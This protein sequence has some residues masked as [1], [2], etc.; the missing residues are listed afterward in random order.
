MGAEVVVGE[1][2]G[3]GQ[4]YF[5]PYWYHGVGVT[6]QRAHC[7][8]LSARL[9]AG[10]WSWKAGL[11]GSLGKVVAVQDWLGHGSWEQLNQAPFGLT[12][13]GSGK[14]TQRP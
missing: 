6:V 12:E 5:L 4:F 11:V 3:L 8:P 1:K 9:W 13:R 2:K 7:G 14:G 10:C